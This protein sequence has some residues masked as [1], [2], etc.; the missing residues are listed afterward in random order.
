[1]A[2]K[3]A[4]G[5]DDIDMQDDLLLDLNLNEPLENLAIVTEDTMQSARIAEYAR[6]LAFMED[7]LTFTIGMS[8]IP[9][10]VD[11][12]ECAVN[13]VKRAYYRG[14]EYK[15]KRMFVN[16][17]LNVTW[18]IN[19]VSRKDPATGLDIST[20]QRTP[21]QAVNIN[22]THDPAGAVGSKWFA[23]KLNGDQVVSQ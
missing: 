13:G 20:I 11:P 14:R 3:R 15:D 10:A 7:V 9:H 6:D 18:D 2:T 21:R 17:L 12:V 16:T 5:V 23:Y 19:V 4:V 8:E 22:I 1:M